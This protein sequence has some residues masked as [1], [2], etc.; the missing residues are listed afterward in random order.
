MKKCCRL[1]LSFCLCWLIF[2]FVTFP[3]MALTTD[4]LFENVESACD[5]IY[6]TRLE[7]SEEENQN[8]ITSKQSFSIT[9][10]AIYTFF[11]I[12]EKYKEGFGDKGFY[13]SYATYKIAA[14]IFLRP[15]AAS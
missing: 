13:G 2:M 12:D 7:Y 3:S 4:S 6:D 8:S 15:R 10:I 9:T 1:F 14:D 5:L 11:N